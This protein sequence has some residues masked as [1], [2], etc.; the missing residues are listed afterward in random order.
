MVHEAVVAFESNK[1]RICACQ[2]V[3]DMFSS[4]ILFKKESV[5]NCRAKKRRKD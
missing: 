4:F 3:L 1:S 5:T 2:S